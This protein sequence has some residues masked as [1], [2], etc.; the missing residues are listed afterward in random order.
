[1]KM[2]YGLFTKKSNSEII[3]RTE[4]NS[5]EEAIEIFAKIKKLSFADLTNIFNIKVIK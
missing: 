3:H 1:M 2:K 5:I 4:A